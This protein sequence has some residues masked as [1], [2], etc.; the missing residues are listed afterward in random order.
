[1]LGTSESEAILTELNWKLEKL[2]KVDEIVTWMRV[3]VF[4]LEFIMHAAISTST[5]E[6]NMKGKV[7]GL[8]FLSGRLL[9]STVGPV[10]FK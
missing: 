4:Y 6:E 9:R 5:A 8:V 3:S 10:V 2:K 1:M 7:L